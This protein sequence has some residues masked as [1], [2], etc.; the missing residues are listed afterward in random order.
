MTFIVRN[1]LV[2]VAFSKYNHQ[3]VDFID[4]QA[5]LDDIYC[6]CKPL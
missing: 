5:R 6:Y 1:V 4:A 3:Q 2:A